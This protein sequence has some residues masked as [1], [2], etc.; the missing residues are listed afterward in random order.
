MTS[1]DSTEERISCIAYMHADYVEIVYGRSWTLATRGRCFW[2]ERRRWIDATWK[3]SSSSLAPASSCEKE[4][5]RSNR[6]G[7]PAPWNGERQETNWAAVR[8]QLSFPWFLDRTTMNLPLNIS[9]SFFLKIT[10]YSHHLFVPYFSSCFRPQYCSIWKGR[11]TGT[12]QIQR[13]GAYMLL[14]DSRNNVVFM[15]WMGWNVARKNLTTCFLLLKIHTQKMNWSNES[16]P[17]FS[18]EKRLAFD[19]LKYSTS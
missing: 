5:K 8:S 2:R 7:Q 6:V 13:S 18:N 17:F 19:A 9:G 12:G 4:V 16:Y 15:V 11:K 1:Y 14:G 3:S 10:F